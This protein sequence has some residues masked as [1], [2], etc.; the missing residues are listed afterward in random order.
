MIGKKISG[1]FDEFNE[2]SGHILKSQLK[3]MFSPRIK[4]LKKLLSEL[5]KEKEKNETILIVAHGITNR[6]IIGHFLEIPLKRQL[7]FFRQHNTC[8]NSLFWDKEHGNWGMYCMNDISHLP[9]KLKEEI[10]NG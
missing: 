3:I 7:L 5:S 4:K 8:I 1:H 6:I 10:K 2:Y 9:D